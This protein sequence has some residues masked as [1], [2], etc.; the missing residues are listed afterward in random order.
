MTFGGNFN[1]LLFFG[2]L[3]VVEKNNLLA[4][5]LNYNHQN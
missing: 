5:K 3:K 1:Y 2:R 4:I